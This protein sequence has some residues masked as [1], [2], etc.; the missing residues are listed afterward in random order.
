MVNKNQTGYIIAEDPSYPT[1]DVEPEHLLWSKRRDIIEIRKTFLCQWL[2]AAVQLWILIFFMT[3]IYLGS[4]HNPNRYTTNLEV[5]IIDADGDLA[6]S[7][8]IN[9]FKQTPSGRLSLHW[10]YKNSNDYDPNDVTDGKVWASVYLRSNTTKL[11]NDSLVLFVNASTSLSS[12]FALQQPVIVTYESGRNVF[13]ISNYVIPPIQ[14]ALA[15]ANS[16]CGQIIRKEL[17]NYLYSSTNTSVNRTLQLLNVLQLESFFANPLPATYVNLHPGAPF[18][19]QLATTLG[20]IYLYLVAGMIVGSTMV[21]LTPLGKLIHIDQKPLNSIQLFFLVGKVHHFDLLCFRVANG[22]FQALMISLIYSLI[23]LW[24]FGIH[25]G[26]QFIRYWMFNWLSALVFGII[27]SL[28]TI[29]LGVIANTIL[30]IFA[31][32]MLA[33]AAL[34][35]SLELSP[36]FY[37]YGYGLPFFNIV[38]G[39]RHLLFGAHSRFGI[40]V[41]V[42]VI[43]FGIFWIF[44]TLTGIFWM[45]RAMKKK[46]ES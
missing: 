28:F 41:G 14:A 35:I 11:I 20:Y 17:I 42:L 2:F 24:F 22:F 46:R 39:A 4:G 25:S 18:V 33:G 26:A 13:T 6:G 5:D 19:G 40:N 37:R 38:S 21:F 31:I 27:V 32:L 10:I 3:I 7:C 12:P 43:Y 1:P 30:T 45:K 29:N 34:Q 16:K 23:V 36:R 15:V 9:A 44:A 8:L